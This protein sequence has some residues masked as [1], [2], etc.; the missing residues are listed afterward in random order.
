MKD[1]DSIVW[2]NENRCRLVERYTKHINH[3]MHAF[4]FVLKIKK[5]RQLAKN[6]K[7]YALVDF[8]VFTVKQWIIN[9]W[10]IGVVQW[11]ICAIK[12]VVFSFRCSWWFS[13]GIFFT[14]WISS[15]YICIGTGFRWNCGKIHSNTTT[16]LH[17]MNSRSSLVHRRILKSHSF[18]IK[19]AKCKNIP[20]E[21]VVH[22]KF[23]KFFCLH[24]IEALNRFAP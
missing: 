22:T 16:I 11:G 14:N 7:Q 1:S 19:C 13:V 15:K 6:S 3:Y 20:F 5:M 9:I 21:P 24:S 4:G 8:C 17:C 2:L 12:S 23:E 18:E 10:F